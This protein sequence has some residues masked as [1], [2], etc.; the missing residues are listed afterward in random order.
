MCWK[1]WGCANIIF[2]WDLLDLFISFIRIGMCFS[3]S[4][5]FVIKLVKESVERTILK[6]SSLWNVSI[7][8]R[9]SH[10]GK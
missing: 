8:M 7:Y 6:N 10:N 2:L 5:A 1:F 9:N 4:L 3:S